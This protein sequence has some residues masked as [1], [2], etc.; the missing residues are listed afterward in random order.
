MAFQ[1]IDRRTVPDTVFDQLVDEVLDGELAPGAALPAERRLAEVLGVSRPTVREALQRLAHTG[2]VEVRQGGATTV[3]DFRRSAGVDML[4]RLI[5]RKGELDHGVIRSIL[6]TRLS[7]GREVA[8][9]AAERSGADLAPLLRESVEV[10]AARRDPVDQQRAALDFWDHVVD[11]ADSIVFRL[12]FNN[13]RAVYEPAMPAL[14]LVM[15]AE[16]SRI[17]CYR[18]LT[19]AVAA[20]DG[21]AAREAAHELLASATTEFDAVMRRLE[22]ERP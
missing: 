1:R 17:D 18:T 21:A 14:T 7:M 15:G 20:G 12:L 13:L 8:G 3:R 4:P 2:L 22:E 16:V 6:E 19:E 10:L 11:G 5:L 9:F